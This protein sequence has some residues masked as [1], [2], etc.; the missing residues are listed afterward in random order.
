MELIDSHC[1]L[2][3]FK[4]KGELK[5]MFERATNAGVKRFITVGTSPEDWVPYREMRAA[6]AG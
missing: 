3:G 6:Y 1:H 2:K 5:P 4:D